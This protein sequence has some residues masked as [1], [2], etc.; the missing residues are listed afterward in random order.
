MSYNHTAKE[1]IEIT[2]D[3]SDGTTEKFTLNDASWDDID[4]R[5]GMLMLRYRVGNRHVMTLIP[6]HRIASIHAIGDLDLDL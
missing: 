6:L 3:L 2:V 4:Q 1:T 5:D